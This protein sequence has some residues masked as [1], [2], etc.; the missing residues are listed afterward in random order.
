MQCFKVP[1]MRYLIQKFIPSDVNTPL[2]NIHSH[3]GETVEWTYGAI[4]FYITQYS[5]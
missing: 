4:L 1:F 3:N 2:V 5:S